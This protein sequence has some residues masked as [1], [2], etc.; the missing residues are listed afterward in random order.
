MRG[1]TMKRALAFLLVPL[2]LSCGSGAR[3][4]ESS[5]ASEVPSAGA[6]V[7]QFGDFTLN[8]Y[9]E[10]GG[11]FVEDYTGSEESITVPNEA[12]IEGLTAPIVGIGPYAFLKRDNLKIVTLQNNLTTL[13]AN[14]FSHSSVRNLY[15]TRYLLDIDRTAF[16]DSDVVFNHMEDDSSQLYVP[17]L[18][19]PHCV[20]FATEGGSGTVY[21]HRQCEAVASHVHSGRP[22][23]YSNNIRC[24]GD[25][26]PTIELEATLDELSL[27]HIGI[28]ALYKC[29]GLR[30]VTISSK[31]TTIGEEAFYECSDLTVVRDAGVGLFPT[32]IINVGAR[33]FYGCS[34]LNINSFYQV[35]GEIEFGEE[36]FANCTKISNFSF[37][38]NPSK[39]IA[40]RMFYGCTSLKEITL[41]KSLVEIGEEA[42][43]KCEALTALTFPITLE[44]IG[45]DAFA[46]C[47][48]L[49]NFYY[50]GSLEKWQKVNGNGEVPDTA[51]F[52]ADPTKYDYD[53]LAFPE[54]TTAIDSGDWPNGFYW[55]SQVK[56][57]STLKTILDEAFSGRSRLASISFPDSLEKIGQKAFS[58]CQSLQ[59]ISFGNGS[60]AIE[61]QNDAFQW[62]TSLTS[63]TIPESVTKLG[64]DVFYRCTE[65]EEATLNCPITILPSGLFSYCDSLQKVN[66]PSSVTLIRENAFS[67]CSNLGEIE[68][69]SSVTHI[70]ESAFSNCT[71]LKTLKINRNLT[72][73]DRGA[74]SGCS[75]LTDVYFDGSIASFEANCAS[76]LY[77]SGQYNG[78]FAG[79]NV[80]VIHCTD[81]DCECPSQ[82]L[83]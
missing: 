6:I 16:E 57:P 56:L 82:V 15:A 27:E 42:F 74:F 73:I 54:G 20:F 51:R 18:S 38:E 77:S 25:Q 65:L 53:Y 52:A 47:S 23:R 50:Q 71:N 68:I 78:A 13:S 8:Y 69:P 4:E 12:K 64:T 17:S 48:Y 63:V 3:R 30:S 35:E 14:A 5:S 21:L 72:W 39:R 80:S 60:S 45:S 28:R 81:G 2:L 41:P 32:G 43:A 62:C 55:Y 26:D 31:A 40:K 61:I 34:Q 49:K 24:I 7:L 36:C 44:K 33:A 46:D 58:Y 83:S 59:S 75:S 22:I 10:Y 66:L 79:T 67:S 19:N 29:A 9:D 11:Y 76:S 37:S 70:K 1:R